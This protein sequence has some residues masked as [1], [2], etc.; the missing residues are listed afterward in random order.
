MK[1]RYVYAMLFG[2]PGLFVAGIVS[3][4]V[5]GA[6]AGALWLFV[7]GDNPWPQGAE[8]V[9]SVLFVLFFLALWVGIVILGHG[10]GRRL[11]RDPA[12]NRNHVL[13]SAGLTVFFLLL[14]LFQQWSVGNLGPRSDTVL[15]SEFCARHGYSGSGMP[16]ADSG[17]RICTCYD[18][19]GKEVLTVPLDHLEFFQ[20]E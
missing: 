8:T 7:F 11:E 10:I 6:F 15:C 3:I 4:L 1:K 13:I 18:D 14:V 16:P 20:P 12:L 17:N 9:I 5:F 19:T 2:I